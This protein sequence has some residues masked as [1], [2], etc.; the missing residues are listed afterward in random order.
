MVVVK[1][2][3]G[4]VA[5]ED[6]RIELGDVIVTMYGQHLRQNASLIHT[7]RTQH[8]GKPVPIGVVKARM[9]DGS[10]YRPLRSILRRYGS[11]QLIPLTSCDSDSI[12]KSYVFV[13]QLCLACMTL[14]TLQSDHN[15]TVGIWKS[16]WIRHVFE[17]IPNRWCLVFVFTRNFSAPASVL[18]PGMY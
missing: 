5:A 18:D 15:T 7:L 14:W 6:Q 13:R 12:S 17:P 3:P 2:D 1:L 10:V 9:P 4:G 11:A 8:E 16:F